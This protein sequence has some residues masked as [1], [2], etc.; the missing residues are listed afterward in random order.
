MQKTVSM[1]YNKKILYGEDG[2]SF[3]QFK[4]SPAPMVCSDLDIDFTQTSHY[5][6]RFKQGIEHYPEN[7]LVYDTTY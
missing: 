2:H 1:Q 7:R 3:S 4:D 6:C 5:F